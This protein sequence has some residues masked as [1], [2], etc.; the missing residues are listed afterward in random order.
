MYVCV[1]VC[2]KTLKF[3]IKTVDK[4]ELRENF[5]HEHFFLALSAVIRGI[6][7]DLMCND[8]IILL[9][10]QNDTKKTNVIR[11]KPVKSFEE[12]MLMLEIN[13]NYKLVPLFFK[14]LA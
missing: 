2:V 6:F 13:P 11:E 3:R 7:Y 14:F 9:R 5:I 8:R 10:N 1:H 12:S 4:K